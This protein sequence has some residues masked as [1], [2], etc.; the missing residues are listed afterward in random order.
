MR[1]VTQY[2]TRAQK[3]LRIRQKM[4]YSVKNGVSD[5]DNQD[6]PQR[7]ARALRSCCG[8]SQHGLESA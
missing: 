8:L 2:P 4:D 3:N 5:D 7:F 1:N 6:A